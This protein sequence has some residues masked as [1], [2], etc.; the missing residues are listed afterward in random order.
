MSEYTEQCAV[1]SWYRIQ[2]KNYHGCLFAIPNGSFLAGGPAKR[3]MQM[4]RL[5]KEGLKKGVSDLFLAVPAG[6][7]HG[8][9]LEMKDV[10]K[11]KCSVSSEQRDHIELMDKMGYGAEWAAGFEQAKNIITHYMEMI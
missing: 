11:T 8:L 7:F 2:Y 1:I 5:K 4:A 3:A 10:K 9:F 6:G